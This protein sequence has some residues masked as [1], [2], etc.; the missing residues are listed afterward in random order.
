VAPLHAGA[1]QAVV[2]GGIAKAGLHH[3]PGLPVLVSTLAMRPEGASPE[4]STTTSA[5]TAAL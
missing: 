2:G 3:D 5:A 1:T 4:C